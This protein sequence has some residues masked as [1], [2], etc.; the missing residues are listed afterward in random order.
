MGLA[1]TGDGKSVIYGA[2]ELSVDYLWRVGVDDQG[3]AERIEMAGV[4]AVFP[5]IT[6]AG[7]R[8]VFARLV[9]DDDI[10]RSNRGDRHSQWHHLP[11]LTGI[12]S[13]LRM[14]GELPSPRREQARRWTCGSPVRTGRNQR[15]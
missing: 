1:W 3:P 13:F 14:A 11:C 7:D 8:L 2:E 4:N 6:P 5:S 10:F 9:D 15:S 12:R